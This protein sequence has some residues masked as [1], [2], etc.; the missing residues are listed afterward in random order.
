ML[1]LS[2]LFF[3]SVT[4]LTELSSL[5]LHDALPIYRRRPAPGFAVRIFSGNDS[6]VE[7]A[8]PGRAPE[9]VHHGRGGLLCA[10]REAVDQGNFTQI[11]GSGCRF[12]ARRRRRNF[13]SARAPDY[14]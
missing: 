1:T 5:S 4:S 14:L 6:R 8:L 10:H 13:P 2:V 9:S 3:D 11:K 12:P 7:T